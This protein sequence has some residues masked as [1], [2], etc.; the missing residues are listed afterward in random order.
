M[1]VKYETQWAFRVGS[2]LY[3]RAGNIE[4]VHDHIRFDGDN[5]HERGSRNTT[6][7]TTNKQESDALI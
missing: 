1:C 5:N 4:G 2:F 3:V 7:T 6:P